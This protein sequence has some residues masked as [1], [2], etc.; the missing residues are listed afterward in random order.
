MVPPVLNAAVAQLSANPI[1]LVGLSR[2][3][4]AEVREGRYPF[5][6]FDAEQ[7]WHQRIFADERLDVWLLSWLPTQ[8]TELHDHGG[9]SGG[10]T[11]VE[12]SLDEAVFRPGAPGARLLEHHRSTGSGVG[13]GPHY[14]HD[15]RNLSS[16]PAVSVHVYSPPLSSMNYY[17]IDEAGA[18]ER[19]ATLIT[20]D[21][22]PSFGLQH[23]A[24][25]P[26]A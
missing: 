15:V 23:G 11:V 20:D 19:I 17:D 21:P 12:G 9:S 6:Q 26:A 16:A 4:A 22:E 18:L 3:I 5:I 1:E 25:V 13:F 14:V 24:G 8:G 10:F 7:R 2:K